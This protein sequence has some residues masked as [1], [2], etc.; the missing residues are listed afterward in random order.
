MSVFL[1]TGVILA[2][3]NAD[4]H[5]HE[6]GFELFRRSLEGEFGRIYSSD[7]VLDEAMTVLLS[8]R[9]NGELARN[10][11]GAIL[12]S[13]LIET[14][15]TDRNVFMVAIDK[16]GKHRK[17]KFEFHRLHYL[18]P[19]G[20]EKDQQSRFFRPGLF[21]ACG[22]HQVEQNSRCA[23]L[24]IRQLERNSRKWSA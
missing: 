7:Y 16:F 15:W 1:D 13:E 21:R 23:R 12:K 22:S 5:L 10:V 4:D 3:R 6:R 18:E 8:R 20:G 2:A 24:W 19:H 14:L 9:K 11:A 17:T